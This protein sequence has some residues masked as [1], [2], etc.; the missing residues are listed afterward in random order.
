[1]QEQFDLILH[2]HKKHQL[3]VNLQF[4]HKGALACLNL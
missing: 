2:W 3:L 1:M 4:L